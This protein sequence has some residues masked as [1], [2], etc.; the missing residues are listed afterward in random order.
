MVMSKFEMKKNE[1]NFRISSLHD[2]GDKLQNIFIDSETSRTT[3]RQ[4]HLET[5]N[6]LESEISII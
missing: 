6:L 3:S 4:K 1:I 2:D 5:V